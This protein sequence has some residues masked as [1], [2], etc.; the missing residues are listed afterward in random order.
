MRDADLGKP[1]YEIRDAFWNSPRLPLL[2]Y[3]EAE[4]RAAIFG[5]VRA[6]DLALADPA[7]NPY[8]AHAEAEINLQST[9]IRLVKPGAQTTVSVPNVTGMSVGTATAA[10]VGAGLTISVSGAGNVVTQIP[11]AGSRLP[12]GATITVTAVAGGGGTGG[13]AATE[14]QVRVSTI[15][16]LDETVVRDALRLLVTQIANAIDAG[17]SHIRLTAEVTVDDPSREALEDAAKL[18]GVTLSV[19]EL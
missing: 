4:L 7:G 14:Y 6:G 10:I 19:T 1:L 16:A 8:T 18:A 12:A 17:A 9:S 15:S 2:H 5:A 3:G 11:A 13:A